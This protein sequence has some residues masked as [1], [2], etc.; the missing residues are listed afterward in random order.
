MPSSNCGPRTSCTGCGCSVCEICKALLS[1][2]TPGQEGA[3]LNVNVRYTPSD[4]VLA[5]R[6][7]IAEL[8]AQAEKLKEDDRRLEYRYCCEIQMKDQ[9][10]D[11]IRG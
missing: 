7:R 5:L 9:L 4:E 10:I 11:F 1:S 8:E 3:A 6:Q 2:L